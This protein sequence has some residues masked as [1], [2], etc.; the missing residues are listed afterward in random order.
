MLF[1]SIRLITLIVLCVYLCVIA[2]ADVWLCLVVLIYLVNVILLVFNF[3]GVIAFYLVYFVRCCAWFAVV[4]F[5]V[6]L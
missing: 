1:D 2:I 4:W 3:V 5:R 6:G